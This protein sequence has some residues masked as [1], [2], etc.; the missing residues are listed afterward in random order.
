MITWFLLF[1]SGG[2]GG[3]ARWLLTR[4]I[5]RS[6]LSRGIPW[7]TVAVNGLGCLVLGWALGTGID[8]LDH[9][10]WSKGT[11]LAL[12]FTGGFTTV[13][14]MA[15]QTALLTKG[16]LANTGPALLYFLANSVAGV[17]GVVVGWGIGT[18]GWS[19]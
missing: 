19:A 5:D 14:T 6:A 18:G 1:A 16:S 15:L 11:L 7:G 2:L 9:E 12:G 8:P 3:I 17:I 10:G 13:S 4:W